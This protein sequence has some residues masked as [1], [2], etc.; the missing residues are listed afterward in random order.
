MTTPS[1]DQIRQMPEYRTLLHK[2]RKVAVPLC[3]L[4]LAVYY[5][6]ILMVAYAP[7]TLSQPVGNGPMTVGIYAGLG[8]ILFTLAET[9]FYVWYAN[10]QLDPLVH[11]IQEKVAKS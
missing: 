11:Q 2:R 8:L 4:M 5:T 9:A 10:H 7:A 1:V 6:F 3:L